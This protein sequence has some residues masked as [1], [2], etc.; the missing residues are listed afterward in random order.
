VFGSRE[1]ALRKAIEYAKQARAELNIDEPSIEGVRTLLLLSQIM[2]QEGKSR[3]SY[4]YLGKP[5]GLT[6]VN[7]LM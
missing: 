1:V 4:M 6:N 3:K 2:L 5:L 7:M